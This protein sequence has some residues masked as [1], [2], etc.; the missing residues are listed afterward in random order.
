[1]SEKKLPPRVLIVDDEMLQRKIVAQQLLKL[2]F[3]SEGVAT[4]AEA[5]QI[6]Q[7]K[8]F[9]VVLLDVQ[10]SDLSGLEAL[11]LIKQLEDAPEVIML[12]LDKTLESGVIA[13]RAGA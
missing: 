11:P 8:D 12:T 4:A 1:M 9:D 6:L 2:E 3:A 5:L 7:T 10:M 13:L